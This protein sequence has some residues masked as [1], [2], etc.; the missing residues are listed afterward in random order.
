M[1]VSQG[2]VN[3]VGNNSATDG[4]NYPILQGKSLE[5]VVTE[6]HGK[7]YTQA[8]R[9]NVYIGST[10]AAGV[11]PPIYNNT[12][13]TFAI[14]N[15]TGSGKN[16]VPIKLSVGLVTVGVV[17]ASH[18]WS[19]VAN[20]GAQV[21]TGGTISA[22]TFV[23]PVNALLGSGATSVSKFAPATITT[24]APSYL[25]PVGISS[26]MATTPTAANSF[27]QLTEYY[28]G[29]LIVPPGTAIFL[30]SNIAGV[31]TYAQSLA[32]EEVP[33]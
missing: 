22:G 5:Q 3:G 33:I 1:P 24:V 32:W 28:D 30:A 27:W 16:I 15:P 19:Y 11:V 23:A 20:A 21:A 2:L 18:C 13:Q 25:R 29:D 31:A 4:N 10:A 17:T 14:W 12:A 7:Y 6:L 26:F 8:Y 9:G